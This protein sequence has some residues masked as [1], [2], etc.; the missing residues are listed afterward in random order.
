MTGAA[1]FSSTRGSQ[2]ARSAV[3]SGVLLGGALWTKPTGGALALGVALAWR[4]WAAH[5]F[6][7]AA[8]C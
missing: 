2:D 6:R 3:V 4:W 5:R 1:A 8:G 7:P